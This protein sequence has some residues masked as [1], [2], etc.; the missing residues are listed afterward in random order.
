MN[1]QPRLLT[2]VFTVNV[3]KFDNELKARNGNLRSEPLRGE[4]YLQETT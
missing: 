4:I 2:V 3:E 1:W